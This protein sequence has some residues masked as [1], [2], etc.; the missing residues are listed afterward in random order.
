MNSLKRSL[1][2]ATLAI[3]FCANAQ[4]NARKGWDAPPP[5]QKLSIGFGRS[6]PNS[7]VKDNA[8]VV[9]STTINADV[10]LSLLRK[11]GANFNFGIN[12]GG[13]YS[14]GSSDNS[15]SPL[16]A[17]YTITGATSSS[18]VYKG[19][20]PRNPGFRIGAGPQA[21]FSLG[22]FVVSPMVLG[23]YFSMTQKEMSIVQTTQYNGQSYDFT[24]TKMPETKTTG[25]AITPKLRLQYILANGLGFFMEGAYTSGPKIETQQTKL[26]P[27]GNPNQ[28][29]NS[30]NIQQL[31][32]ATYQNGEITKTT[33]NAMSFGGGISFA[34]GGKKGWNGKQETTKTDYKGWNGKTETANA[35]R[36]GWDGTVKGLFDIKSETVSVAKNG[37]IEKLIDNINK[38]GKGKASLYKRP[39]KEFIQIEANDVKSF[40]EIDNSNPSYTV[41]QT[42]GVT[43]KVALCPNGSQ[44][45]LVNLAGRERCA[46]EDGTPS[47]EYGCGVGGIALPIT[48]YIVSAS[49]LSAI[50]VEAENNGTTVTSTSIKDFHNYLSSVL[51]KSV[52]GKSEILTEGKN[53]YLVTSVTENG[54]ENAVYSKLKLVRGTGF[55]VE[56]NAIMSCFGT[57]PD[58][59]SQCTGYIDYSGDR[60]YR[61]RCSAKCSFRILV[62]PSG[63][64]NPVYSGPISAD[65]IWKH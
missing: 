3:S 50:G 56:R 19:V 30:Y 2:A 54:E 27:N 25:F 62:L 17:G 16:P 24:L 35:I 20:D 1:L 64:S 52:V 21:N 40:Y 15:G 28:Q 47:T 37:G 55:I 38:G 8:N 42:G 32:T 26:I 29:S 61:C 13:M 53:K 34:F 10:F 33:Y 44:C 51:P 11:E 49:N 22:R 4:E 14:F 46:C 36:K 45:K 18:I 65:N 31:Q 63:P 48:T 57:C 58:N 7:T 5:K 60:K 59:G 9:N 39:D 6:I 41:I 23:E 12:L 43:C